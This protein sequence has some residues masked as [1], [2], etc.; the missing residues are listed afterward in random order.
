[1]HMHTSV[2][3][4]LD[5]KKNQHTITDSRKGRPKHEQVRSITA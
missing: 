1:M 3:I 2:Y 5:T 4:K